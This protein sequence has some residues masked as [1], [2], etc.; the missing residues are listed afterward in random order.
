LTLAGFRQRYAPCDSSRQVSLDRSSTRFEAI[1]NSRARVRLGH[2]L[3]SST[4]LTPVL[5]ATYLGI[6]ALADHS[7][8]SLGW[9]LA[10][11]C[12]K[13]ADIVAL[14]LGLALFPL[15]AQRGLANAR[16]LVRRRRRLRA[17][18][19]GEGGA[20]AILARV[21]AQILVQPRGALAAEPGWLRYAALATGFAAFA[22]ARR[23]TLAGVVCGELV[24]LAGQ[25][26]LR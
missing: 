13:L 16:T 5:F 8:F 26:W 1:A 22:A 3:G 20:T 18:G 25:W 4:V 24:M 11:N 7:H 14:A 12:R 19:L 2:A 10:S 21:I 15:A 9:A 6:G 17:S 23:S